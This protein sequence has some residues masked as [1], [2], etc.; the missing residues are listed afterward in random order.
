MRAL[1]NAVCIQDFAEAVTCVPC[2]VCLSL[3]VCVC[4][5][6][7]IAR[8]SDG[9]R[10]QWRSSVKSLH[11]ATEVRRFP[12]ATQPEETSRRAGARRAEPRRGRRLL[13][14]SCADHS[15]IGLR[16]V[17]RANRSEGRGGGREQREGWGGNSRVNPAP[18]PHL[19]PCS[20][21]FFLLYAHITPNPPPPSTF[22]PR[23]TK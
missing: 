10:T 14:G 2:V 3:C 13:I 16:A 18:S 20:S 11:T 8:R 22:T 21:F 23:P 4:A 9:V 17:F 1:S 7:L 19:S 12:V 6:A 5:R 15:Q